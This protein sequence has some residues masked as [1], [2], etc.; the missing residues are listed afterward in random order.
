[1]HDN[2]L[3]H[4]RRVAEKARSDEKNP[5]DL[6]SEAKLSKIRSHQ[7]SYMSHG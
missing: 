4:V 1:M 5:R 7:S 2:T 3:R 6:A